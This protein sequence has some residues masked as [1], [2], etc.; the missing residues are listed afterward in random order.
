VIGSLI[1]G[2]VFNGDDDGRSCVCVFGLLGECIQ[3]F[4]QGDG[5]WFVGII[6]GSPWFLFLDCA[7]LHCERRLRSGCWILVGADG[8]DLDFRMEQVCMV[9]CWL[10]CFF[11]LVLGR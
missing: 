4:H 11:E 1:F 9:G 5:F 7:F 3:A 6:S 2:V 8:F 10:G